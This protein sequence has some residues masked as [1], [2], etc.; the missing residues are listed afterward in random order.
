MHTTPNH[1]RRAAQRRIR[2][3]RATAAEF[4]EQRKREMQRDLERRGHEIA[5]EQRPRVA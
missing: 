2:A 4:I 1:R 3:A 5:D